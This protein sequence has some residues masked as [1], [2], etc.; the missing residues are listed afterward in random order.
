[1]QETETE[2]MVVLKISNDETTRAI[3]KDIHR[4]MEEIGLGNF[5]DVGAEIVGCS[6]NTF[7]NLM[8][9]GTWHSDHFKSLMKN[10]KA[11]FLKEVFR[12]WSDN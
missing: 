10:T 5:Y 8:E 9:N 1:M 3:Q 4:H 12:K 2:G 11:T 7:R 6:T